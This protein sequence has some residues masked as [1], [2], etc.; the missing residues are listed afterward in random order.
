[1][2]YI[3]QSGDNLWNIVRNN[4]NCKNNNEIN[5]TVKQIIASND[6]GDGNLI[7]SGQEISLPITDAYIHDFPEELKDWANSI[8]YNN[9]EDF[10]MFD[11]DIKDQDF[12][13]Y[14]ED[15]EQFSK[16]IINKYDKNGDGELDI[17]EYGQFH[18]DIKGKESTV[19]A[20]FDTFNVNGYDDKS[21]K[22]ITAQEFASNL[23]N[24]DKETKFIGYDCVSETKDGKLDAARLNKLVNNPQSYDRTNAENFF[25]NNYEK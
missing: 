25:K 8:D 2:S 3:V 22:T 23:T 14:A 7:F 18:H 9:I 19:R 13:G 21:D 10:E 4:Y 11:Y 6:I 12:Q 17:D 1:M 20:S 15:I 16:E 24:A 5:E